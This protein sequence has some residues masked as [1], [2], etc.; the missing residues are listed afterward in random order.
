VFSWFADAGSF[1][2]DVTRQFDPRDPSPD[3]VGPKAVWREPPAK[4]ERAT[5]W[6]VV[7][8]GRGG[9]TWGRREVIFE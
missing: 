9:I 3:N 4:T 1:R 8:D 2:R 5:I 6:A 7:R